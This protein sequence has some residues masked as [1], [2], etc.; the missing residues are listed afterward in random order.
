MT[1]Q[2]EIGGGV[3]EARI[4]GDTYLSILAWCSSSLMAAK[5]AMDASSRSG[6]RRSSETP[7]TTAVRGGA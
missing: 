5:A 2:D 7:A 6:K 3:D 4:G 1:T